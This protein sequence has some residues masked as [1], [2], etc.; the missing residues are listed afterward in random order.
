MKFNQV[1]LAVALAFPLL[2]S[3]QSNA[4]LQSQILE[5]KAQI[6]QLRALITQGAAAPAPVAAAEQPAVDPEDYNQI[7]VKVEG[8]LDQQ[9]AAGIKGLRISGGM[10]PVYMVNRA[11]GTSSFAFLNNFA[12]TNGSGE[13]YT[14]DNSYFGMA[15]LDVQKEMED[16]GTKFRLTLAPSKSAGSGYNFGNIVHEA[17]VSIPLTDAQTRLI[18]GQIPDFSGYEPFLNNYVGANG[19]TS[20]L[21]FPGYGEY[22][23][24]K[25]MLYDFSA[26]TMYTGVGLDVTR[27]PWETKLLLANFNSA[28]ND[29]S[30]VN[31]TVGST[32][33]PPRP[34]RS[35]T[36]IYNATYAKDEFWGFEF[37]GYEGRVAN[38]VMGGTSR[39]HQ[40][41]ID[42]NFT[43]GDFNGNLQFTV[44]RQADAAFNGGAA[45]WW[46]VSALASQRVLP[47]L[48]LAVR[49]DYLNN[50]KNGGGTFNLFSNGP[51]DAGGVM[52]M[53]DFANGFGPGNPLDPAFDPSKGANRYA[54]SFA[55]TY[56]LTPNVALRGELRHDHSS[57]SSFY[58]YNDQSYKKTNDTLGLQ[59]IVN[60]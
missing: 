15:Y 13:A 20:N 22:F 17:S 56:R 4:E 35:P 36:L 50:E 42:G 24:T 3:A 51:L 49:A 46:G 1:A 21:L 60:F 37:T 12:N 26:A 18:A 52:A 45:Q 44:G 30:N 11:K 33:C 2:A 32:T 23:I 7:K 38:A 55:G 8:M 14:Y 16:G 57:T 6:S 27:G 41:E 25:N 34:V 59:T 10:D 48:T 9:Q 53:G 47:K 40:F 31:C 5:L 39:L 19:L 54:L 28:R 58:Y 29:I 43:K